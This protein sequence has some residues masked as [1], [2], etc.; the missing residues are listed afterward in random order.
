MSWLILLH[1]WTLY[2]FIDQLCFKCLLFYD[3]VDHHLVTKH[4]DS[5]SDEYSETPNVY[6]KNKK[7]LISSNMEKQKIHNVRDKKSKKTLLKYKKEL[8]T[9]LRKRFMTPGKS[10]FRYYCDSALKVIEDFKR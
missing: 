1:A 6:K 2:K 9:A 10:V 7:V 8:T 3:R 4:F 5:G